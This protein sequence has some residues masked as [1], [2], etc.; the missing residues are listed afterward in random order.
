MQN[1]KKLL[2]E[3]VIP[4]PDKVEDFFNQRY[5]ANRPFIFSSV[6]LRHS[7]TK[8]APVDT[9]LFPAGFN[10]LTD[11]QAAEASKQVRL[12]L[13]KYHAGKSRVLLVPENHTRNKMYLNNVL[14][15]AGILKDAG[16]DVTIGGLAFMETFEEV[17]EG[18]TLTVH[19]ISRNGSKVICNGIEPE[20]VILNND[21]SGGNPAILEGLDDQPVIPPA[22][23]GWFKRRK[24]VHFAAYQKV[25]DDFAGAFGFD[26]WLISAL[27]MKCSEINFRA[28]EGLICVADTVDKVLTQTAAKY[29][30]YGVDEQ[31]FAYIKADSGTY[32]MGIMVVRSAQEVL[33]INKKERHSMDKIKEGVEN[34]EVIIQEGVPTIDS[35]SGKT[36]EPMIYLAGGMPV[37]CNYRLNSSKDREGNLNSRGMEFAQMDMETTDPKCPTNGIIARL[38]ALAAAE[39]KY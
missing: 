8:I 30:E 37:G 21:L 14:R 12:Y 6:D 16:L 18:G 2:A 20:L 5:A 3:K 26:S 29:K 39:E 24:S 32:G 38:A 15:L 28:K 22:A 34:T 11:N 13:E 27:S 19:P 17:L 36:A 23:M 4:F 10:L 9:N 31:P 7:G 25:A 33:E 35:Y 1:I